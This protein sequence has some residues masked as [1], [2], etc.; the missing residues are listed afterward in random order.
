MIVCPQCKQPIEDI[1][2]MCTGW[3]RLDIHL[4]CLPL[5]VRSCQACRHHN[6]AYLAKEKP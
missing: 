5:H 6:E 2:S 1:K 4:T 3:C